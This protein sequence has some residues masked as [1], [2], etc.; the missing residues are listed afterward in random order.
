MSSIIRAEKFHSLLALP[1]VLCDLATM[2][3]NDEGEE[4]KTTKIFVKS[5]ATPTGNA[6]RGSPLVRS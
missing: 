2:P 6:D 4:G 3:R 1:L 5:N